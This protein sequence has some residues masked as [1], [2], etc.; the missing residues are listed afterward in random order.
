MSDSSAS[1]VR[2]QEERVPEVE[3][4]EI[5][6][7]RAIEERVNAYYDLDEDRYFYH[8]HEELSKDDTEDSSSCFKP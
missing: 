5:E 2:D 7:W 4:A 8:T 3:S 1:H 6:Q